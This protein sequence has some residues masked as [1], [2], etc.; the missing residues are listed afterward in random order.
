M[1][2]NRFLAVGVAT[3]LLLLTACSDDQKVDTPIVVSNPAGTPVGQEEQNTPPQIRFDTQHNSSNTFSVKEK[4]P[5]GIQDVKQQLGLE[6][7]NTHTDPNV[8]VIGGEEPE[9]PNPEEEYQPSSSNLNAEALKNASTVDEKMAA[10]LAA[11]GEQ[12]TSLLTS[13]EEKVI[14]YAES[15]YNYK[16]VSTAQMT[17]DLKEWHEE[18]KEKAGVYQTEQDGNFFIMISAGPK[19]HSGYQLSVRGVYDEKDEV[20]ILFTLDEVKSGN[21][22]IETNPTIIIQ[23][24]KPS[25]KVNLY[26]MSE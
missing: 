23:M 9:S 18:K 24:K 19:P 26:D 8:V 7:G 11:N 10:I 5:D 25:K 13:T 3:S 16:V 17:K 1:K 15:T 14:Q 21:L 2:N 20:R 4:M 12:D 22:A 6:S